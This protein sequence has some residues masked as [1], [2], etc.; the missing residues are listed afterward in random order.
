LFGAQAENFPVPTSYIPTVAAAVTRS[1][2]SLTLDP[3][4]VNSTNKIIPESV[5]STCAA[6]TITL[7]FDYRCRYA[8]TTEMV[9]PLSDPSQLMD[10]SGSTGT[11]D[12]ARNGTLRGRIY[13]DASGSHYIDT[14]AISN[15]NV[16]KTVKLYVDT[17]DLSRMK[18]SVSDYSGAY[19]YTSVSG[20]ATLDTTN[21]LIRLGNT[22]SGGATGTCWYRNPQ[23]LLNQ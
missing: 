23:I 20:T 19:T 6:K 22:Y 9:S 21:D 18:L 15:H 12:T 14:A 8:S 10:V 1:A 7:I 3:H 11:A 16:W 17:A 5:C 2:E 13:D 4:P